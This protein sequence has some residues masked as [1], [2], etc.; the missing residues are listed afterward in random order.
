MELDSPLVCWAAENSVSPLAPV[1]CCR[2]PLLAGTKTAATGESLRECEP[3]VW[4]AC[5]SFV[6]AVLLASLVLPSPLPCTSIPTILSL[7]SSSRLTMAQRLTFSIL[8]LAIVCI[9]HVL[10]S[11]GIRSCRSWGVKIHRLGQ[12]FSQG[13]NLLPKRW[14]L[15]RDGQEGF[16]DVSWGGS[17]CGLRESRPKMSDISRA[18]AAS[19]WLKASI[20]WLSSHGNLA[21]LGLSCG[22]NVNTFLSPIP[23]FSSSRGM[24]CTYLGV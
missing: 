20:E 19:V 1:D 21:W 16:E 24:I 10:V 7:Q 9:G 2:A 18:V 17:S 11:I 12:N 6:R 8:L 13:L 23:R 3:R 4:L 5:L 14:L 15:C 22:G